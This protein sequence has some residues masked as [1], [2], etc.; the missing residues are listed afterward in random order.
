MSSINETTELQKAGDTAL[1]HGS[2]HIVEL[3]SLRGIAA[4]AV[5]F[6]HVV[7]YYSIP[8]WLVYLGSS[9]MDVRLSSS[10]SC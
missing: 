10:S 9:L 8:A 7:G 2:H 3:Q 6:G 5:L 4:T 1:R